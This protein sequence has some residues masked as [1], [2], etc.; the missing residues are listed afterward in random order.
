MLQVSEDNDSVWIFYVLKVDKSWVLF[1]IENRKS[2]NTNNFKINESFE[3]YAINP[4]YE[5]ILRIFKLSYGW[6]CGT[7]RWQEAVIYIKRLPEAGPLSSTHLCPFLPYLTFSQISCNL[8][9]L[10]SPYSVCL[11]KSPSYF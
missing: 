8:L 4:Y 9:P 3:A 1:A 10:C 2:T 5:R 7:Y 6:R 11:P